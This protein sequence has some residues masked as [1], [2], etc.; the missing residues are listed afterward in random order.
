MA[1][2]WERACSTC[3]RWWRAWTGSAMPA[4]SRS[5]TRGAG[6]RARPCAPGYAICAAFCKTS[7]ARAESDPD[8][9]PIARSPGR[10]TI[11]TDRAKD[12][13]PGRGECTNVNAYVV[14]KGYLIQSDRAGTIGLDL[15]ETAA[16]MLDARHA[17]QDEFLA[18]F[19]PGLPMPPAPPGS[20]SGA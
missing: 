18:A 4:T 7:P 5:S 11:S 6:T 10:P 20:S 8:D 14:Y 12:C 16:A 13:W 15:A 3:P 9:S 19:R 17:A 2:P 1:W